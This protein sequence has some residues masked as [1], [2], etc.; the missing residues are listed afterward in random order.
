MSDHDREP[1]EL[2]RR[3]AAGLRSGQLDP[4]DAFRFAERLEAYLTGAAAG[5]TLDQACGVK[6]GQ[7]DEPWWVVDDRRRR[8]DAI[9]EYAFQFQPAD[10][11]HEIRMYDRGRWRR[12]RHSA[13]M[14]PAY[15]GT[16]RELLFRA[17][18]ANRAVAEEMPSSPAY[19]KR[20]LASRSAE[21]EKAFHQI[22]SFREPPAAAGI[23][24]RVKERGD[25]AAAE[26]NSIVA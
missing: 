23:S 24:R 5:M 15:V 6:P 12:D 25:H 7:G 18:R 10:L 1:I 16:P 11:G 26:E 3:V 13:D 19:L 4:G 21:R 22:P 8:D 20:V 14:P 9:A 17:F 2:L